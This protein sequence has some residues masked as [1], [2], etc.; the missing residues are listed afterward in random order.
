MKIEELRGMTDEELIQQHNM[1]EGDVSGIP[2]GMYLDEL[3]RREMMRQGERMEK[4]TESI[5]WLTRVVTIA[6]IIGVVITGITAYS[7]IF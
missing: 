7:Q 3:H 5:N 4:L 1:I 2:R 6:T